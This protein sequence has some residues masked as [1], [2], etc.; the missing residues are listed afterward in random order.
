MAEQSTNGHV[1]A[2]DVPELP[3]INK[4]ADAPL[5]QLT[6]DLA[7]YEE[8]VISG[9]INNEQWF[10]QVREVLCPEDFYFGRCASV[11]RAFEYLQTNDKPL[12]YLNLCEALDP[13]DMALIGGTTGLARMVA[14]FTS[15][16]SIEDAV[17]MV[18]KSADMRRL[19]KAAEEIANLTVSGEPKQDIIDHATQ[20][21]N[22]ATHMADPEII[23]TAHDA[24]QRV[25][26]QSQ[27]AAEGIMP[28]VI[29]TGLDEFDRQL[30]GHGF[31]QGQ[32]IVIGGRP[33]NGKSALGAWLALQASLQNKRV[34]L[35]SQEMSIDEVTM[36]LASAIS[37]VD[38]AT[39]EKGNMDDVEWNRYTEVFGDRDGVMSRIFIDDRGTINTRQIAARCR[40]LKREA[41]LD[42]VIEDYLQLLAPTKDQ[43][44]LAG[45]RAELV[46]MFSR[47]LKQLARELDIPVIT[48]AQVN[49]Q[50][51]QRP[52][53]R[54]TMADLRESGAIEAD[55]DVIVMT[56]WD[57]KYN[58]N[59]ENPFEME[60]IIDKQRNGPTGTARVFFRP[61]RYQFGNLTTRNING[62]TP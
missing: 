24:M 11:W 29:S 32:S 44:Q 46:G 23:E 41:G 33:G 13:K 28:P 35:F 42:L 49:R 50:V 30:T 9:M 60:L 48:L 54:P 3:P 51:E 40:K 26:R 17:R 59:T 12:D 21:F 20:I 7:P 36:R 47:S 62:G 6:R 58:P 25:Y 57:Y 45:T 2:V 53:K 38:H 19:L 15:R 27:D 22:E 18:K 14:V 55:A 39:I 61:Q 52:D 4:N 56:Y 34:G 43:K 16:R 5:I 37:G 1:I 8:I 31:K 10:A